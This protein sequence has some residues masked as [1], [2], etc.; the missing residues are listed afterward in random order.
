[1]GYFIQ[2]VYVF[3]WNYWSFK[4]IA[5]NKVTKQSQFM[6]NICA[7]C[8]KIPYNSVKTKAHV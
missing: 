6:L 5:R 1:M 3:D 7:I 2:I 4:V 8:I